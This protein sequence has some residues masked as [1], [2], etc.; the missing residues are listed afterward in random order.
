MITGG[1]LISGPADSLVMMDTMPEILVL[2]A[3][4]ATTPRRDTPAKAEAH[5]DAVFSGFTAEKTSTR[6]IGHCPTTVCAV[7]TGEH[8]KWHL[9]T[10]AIARRA[11]R[12]KPLTPN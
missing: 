1:K 2:Q 3:Q 12:L 8:H 9:W 11:E 6:P 7:D 10:I 4:N 5:I